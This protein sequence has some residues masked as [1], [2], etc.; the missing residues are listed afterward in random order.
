MTW[1]TTGCCIERLEVA[2]QGERLQRYVI[3]EENDEVL[4]VLFFKSELVQQPNLVQELWLRRASSTAADTRSPRQ[5]AN[6]TNPMRTPQTFVPVMSLKK[7]LPMK[8]HLSMRLRRLWK[9]R[10]VCYLK[11]LVDVHIK[12]TY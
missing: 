4:S 11:S 6:T 9:L 3:V 10:N 2:K 5:N 7:L 12:D 8:T 1:W